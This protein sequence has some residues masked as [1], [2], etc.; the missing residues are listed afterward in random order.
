MFETFK[1]PS[2]YLAIQAVLAL[3]ATGSTTGLVL[4]SGDGASQAVPVFEGFALRPAVLRLGFA[5]RDV[6]DYLLKI[7]NERGFTFPC[8]EDT[9]IARDIKEKLSYVVADVKEEMKMA[10]TISTRE[11]TYELP[12]GQVRR[13]IVGP[14][15]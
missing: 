8:N 6:T 1:I 5:G 13:K 2:L 10:S 11:N 3:Y 7:L 14:L 9:E 4:D 12:D 15:A